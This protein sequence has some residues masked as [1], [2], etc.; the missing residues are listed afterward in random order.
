VFHN[1]IKREFNIKIVRI[2]RKALL[3]AV[4]VFVLS[5]N[6]VEAKTVL[7]V[8]NSTTDSPCSSLSSQDSLY[9]DRLSNLGYSVK[10]INE[11]HP[12]GNTSVWNDYVS[13]SDMI[14]LGNVGLDMVNTTMYQDIFCGNISSVLNNRALFAAFDNTWFNRS[15]NITGC[16]FYPSISLVSFNYD[17]NR[18]NQKSFKVVKQGYITEG[19]NLNDVIDLYTGLNSIRVYNVSD[20]GWVAVECTPSGGAIDFYPVVNTSS[21][22]VFWGLEVPSIFTNKTWEIFDRTILTAM[23][24]MD[25]A[26]NP[27]VIP[28][29]ATVNQSV[30]VSANVTGKRITGVVNFTA[31][32]VTGGMSY[33]DGLW[34]N[35]TTMLPT[36]KQYYLNITGF[37]PSGLRGSIGITLTVGNLSVIITSASFKPNSDY[38]ISASLFS[39]NEPQE[40]SAASYR[41]LDASNYG[42]LFSGPLLCSGNVCTGKIDSMPD[43][44]GLILEVTA[45]SLTESG[46]SFKIISKEPLI[47][48]KDLYKPG[49]TIRIDF[50]YYESLNQVN[51]TIIKPNGIKETPSPIPM[52]NISSTHWAKNYTLGTAASN[53]TYTINVKTAKGTTVTEFNKTVDVIAWNAFAYLNQYSF[54]AFDNL[55]LTVE[56]TDR[57]STILNYTVNV[58]IIN[59]LNNKVLTANGSIAES[60]VYTLTYPIPMDYKN[61]TSR[62]VINLNDSDGRV[63]I[64][65]LNF[66]VNSTLAAP[67]LFVTPTVLS[68]TTITGKTLE[69]N[70]TIE[71][72]ADIDSSTITVNIS[73][74]LENTVSVKSKPDSIAARSKGSMIIGI[75][76]ST[77][78]EG[79]Y[80]GTISIY[81]RIGNNQISV[82]LVIMG[83]LYSQAQTKLSELL[84]LDK[85]ITEFENKNLNVTEIRS[86][87]DQTKSI[88]EE[89]KT[90]FQNEN[91]NSAQTKLQDASTKIE[92]LKSML[93]RYKV[94]VP[95]YSYIIWYFA[96]AIVVSIVIITV[97]KYGRKLFKKKGKE[98]KGEETEE[99]YYKPQEEYRTEYY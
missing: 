7:Y 95:D 37:S 96:I 84:L 93:E 51:L 79:S 69:R 30:W 90:D 9:C 35:L 14:F 76:A 10:V 55:I 82:S 67:S 88:L 56:V 3:L 64:L 73:K 19:N 17:D 77:L 52:T 99:I 1:I 20:R 25:W 91:Y 60:G 34:R 78:S 13:N 47:T 43:I 66:S 31:D 24:D 32:E 92:N 38:T 86:L 75:D 29:V 53:G 72:S 46:G 61:G 12:Q 36:K 89:V 50:F 71:N 21:K 81:S 97:I 74:S 33:S 45:S 49:E 28:S 42:V 4:L 83:D 80:S 63:S 8:T 23:N 6:M 22:G 98:K 65:N 5:I 27:F 15:S 62:I 2:M 41:I 44:Q 58:N 87:Y 18:C 94:S 39:G 68:E 54:N 85:N 11:D 57:Y 40:A 16:A 48:D 26:I 59:P 70:F